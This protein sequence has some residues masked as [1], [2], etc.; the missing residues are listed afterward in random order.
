AA[1]GLPAQVVAL[2]DLVASHDALLIATPEYNG[3]YTAV[4]K[5]ALDWVS[6][7]RKDGSPFEGQV[8]ALVSASPGHLGGLR[9]HI[10]P[11]MGLDK[12]GVTVIPQHFALGG[13]HEAFDDKRRIKDSKVAALIGAVGASLAR[14]AGA[15]SRIA[16]FAEAA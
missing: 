12:R 16:R 1:H 7:P 8:A 14:A 3:G 11:R 5:N 9:S 13:A 4:L 15:A 10:A 6:R 2:Q